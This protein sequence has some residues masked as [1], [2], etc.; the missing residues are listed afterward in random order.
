MSNNKIINVWSGVSIL[1]G[2][3]IGSGIFF[4]GFQILDRSYQSLPLSIL[5]WIVG[6]LITLFSGLSY[7]ELGTLFPEN[8]G[9]YVYLKK[10]Y[11]HRVA[12]LSGFMNLVLSSSGS[13]ALLAILF[14]QILSNIF[15]AL[16]P[17][18]SLVAF[19]AIALLTVI[20]YC[21]LKLGT[22]VQIVFM[23]AKMIPIVMIIVRGLIVGKQQIVLTSLLEGKSFFQILV[24]FGFAVVGTLWAYEG[25]TNLNAITGHMKDAKK[26]LPKSLSIATLGVMAIYV[27]FI[28]SLYRLVAYSDLLT[29]TYGWFIFNAAYVLFGNAGQLIIMISVA[30]SVFGALNGSILVFPRVYQKMAQ[31][32][33]FFKQVAKEHKKYQTPYIALILSALFASILVALEF[34][35]TSISVESLLTFVVFAGLIFNTLI[36][37]SLFKF[38]K[39][40]P[41]TEY[42]RYQVWGYP[43][44]PGLAIFGLLMLLIAT[45]IE[46]FVPSMIGI[47]V[48]IVGYFM[49][50]FFDKKLKNKIVD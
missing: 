31:D 33:M 35:I 19:F 1:A 34:L 22:M 40:H 8:G 14:S 29:S 47:G 18:I 20:N 38:R 48:L 42:P 30:I 24:A 45:L 3:M 16:G 26:D 5:A 23:A 2:I 41:I 7:A 49:Y 4:L 50:T 13:I 11:G 6:G 43:Y 27:L 17:W 12:F 15:P 10:A 32:G 44:V 46:S 28:I 21:G 39:T 25:W 36:F 9:Y 37:I